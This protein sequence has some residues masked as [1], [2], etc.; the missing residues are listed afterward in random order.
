MYLLAYSQNQFCRQKQA[1]V[2]E[3]AFLFSIVVQ[4]LERRHAT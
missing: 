2:T 3:A 1:V 4:S